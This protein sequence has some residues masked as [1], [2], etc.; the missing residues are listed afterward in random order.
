MTRFLPG[1]LAA[2]ALFLTACGSAPAPP[3]PP[4]ASARTPADQLRYLVEEYWDNYRLLNPRPLPQGA[5]VRFDG[6][7]G[8]DISAQFLA[9]SL[10]LERRYLDAVAALPLERLPADAQLTYDLFKRE[11]ELAV[12]S[13]TYPAELLPVNPFRSVPLEFARTGTGTGPYAILSAKDFD[14]W[15]LRVDDYVRW[16]EEAIANMRDGMRRGYTEPRVL[17]AETL[18]VLGTLAEDT[19]TNVFYS[20]LRSIPASLAEPERKRLSEGISAGV[21]SKILPAYRALRNFLRDE[22]LPRA[23]QSAGLSALP[24]GESWY[25]FLVRRETGSRLK[26]AE[27]HAIGVAETEHLHERL[28]SLLAEAGFAGN[29]QAFH[30]ATHRAPRTAF[31]TAEELENFYDQLK[32]EAA[33]AI[34]ALFEGLPQGDF[35]IRRLEPFREATSPALTYQRA[36][37]RNSSAILYVNMAGIEAEPIVPSI[38]LFL[39][40]AIPGYHYQISIQQEHT[41]LPRFR[42]EGGDPG[43]VEGWGVYAES[44][45]EQLGLYRD[46]ESKFAALADQ[47]EC[48]AGMVVDTGIHALGWSRDQA[49]EYMRSQLPIDEAGVKNAV[50]RIVA[51]P[52]EA[53]A[54]AVGART[55]RGLREHAEQSLGARFELRAFHSELLNDG[56]MP[57]DMLESKLNRR[58]NSPH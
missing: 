25:A 18:P 1:G 57:L 46:T 17:I 4:A 38:A 53:L 40:E 20:P 43:F 6:G 15:Q 28:Q 36:A 41:D 42:R 50:D 39:R 12:E 30:E 55:I 37:N 23:R 13:F 26:P 47:L 16:T 32:G 14:N 9:D 34:P 35:A 5:E 19:P 45:G 10:A 21:K 49:L 48:A 2:A 3:S 52:G 51:S 7:S 8:I 58:L 29:S 56:A 22:Y 24:L 54:C 44:L 11:R 31:K 27:L 33:T